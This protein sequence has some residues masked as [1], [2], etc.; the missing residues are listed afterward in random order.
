MQKTLLVIIGPTAVGKTALS[1][2]LAKRLG[3]EI[4]SGDSR[5]FYQEMS[6]G[7]AKPTEEELAAVPHH[8]INN[9]SIKEYYSAGDFEKEAL[10]KIEAL[11]LS[12]DFVVAIGGSGLYMKALCEGLDEV[13][14]VDMVLRNELIS[15]YQNQGLGYLQQRMLSLNPEKLKKMDSNN[16]QRLMRA[17]ELEM[18]GGLVVKKAKA[19]PFNVVKIGLNMQREVLYERINQR[20]EVMMKMGLLHEVSSLLPYREVN[21]MQT[22]GYSELVEHLDGLMTLEQAVDKIKQHTR[23]YAKRQMTWFR[24][25]EGIHWF[26]PNKTDDIE[27][28]VKTE[29]AKKSS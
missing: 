19:R 8:F 12:H 25:D 13:P 6:I 22:V 24:A 17:I 10:E 2:E 14:P 23:N 21:A 20:V 16:P 4:V 27:L 5:Q 28:F 3:T 15:A 9:R 11:F 29:A 26:E 18:Q 1:I 7:T